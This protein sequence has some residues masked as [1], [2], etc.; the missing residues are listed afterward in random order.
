MVLVHGNGRDMGQGG[1]PLP[2]KVDCLSLAK[3]LNVPWQGITLPHELDC[4]R[5]YQCSDV[6]I[7]EKFC[8]DRVNTRFDPKNNWCEWHI[9]VDCITFYPWLESNSSMKAIFDKFKK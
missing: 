9:K 4:S 1:K 8:A 5:F 3:T 7:V 6:G 2:P